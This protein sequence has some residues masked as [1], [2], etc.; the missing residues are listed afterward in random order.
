MCGSSDTCTTI[1]DYLACLVEEDGGRSMM[2]GKLEGYFWW[3]ARIGKMQRNLRKHKRSSGSTTGSGSGPSGG[4][5][6]GKAPP[7]NSIGKT[8]NAGVSGG[9]VGFESAALKR[10]TEWQRGQAPSNKR[11]RTRG[12]GTM[13][14]TSGLSRPA[15]TGANVEALEKESGEVSDM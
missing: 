5:N 1:G 11:R 9:N 3:K 15:A 8:S 13:S 10:K 14:V 4:T 2:L 6:N 12:G 7:G